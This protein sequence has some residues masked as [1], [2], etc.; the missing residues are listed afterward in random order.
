[1]ISRLKDCMA[2]EQTGTNSKR[3]DQFPENFPAFI[4]KGERCYVVG[5]DGKRYVDF[6]SAL[7]ANILGYAH[8]AVSEAVSKQAAKGS[9]FSLPSFKEVEVAEKIKGLIPSIEQLRFLKNGDDAARAAIRIARAYTNK[10][11]VLVKG[12]HGHSDLF[13]SLTPPSLGIK[14][15]FFAYKLSEDFLEIEKFGNSVACVLVE[16]LELSKSSPWREWLNALQKKC[17]KRGIVFIVDE[18]ITGFRVPTMS[19]SRWW[20]LDPDIVLL[21][22]AIANGYPLS[23]VGGKKKIM[24]STEY[25][26]SSTFSGDAVSLAAAEATMHEIETKKSLEDLMFYGT[27]LMN[28]LNDLHP[29]MKWLGWGTRA[30]FNLTH[31]ISALFAQEMCDAGYLFGKAWFFNFAHLEENIEALVMPVAE[32]VMTKIRQGN[33]KL[34]GKIPRETFEVRKS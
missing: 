10:Q 6:I 31:P 26:I 23:V 25:F 4:E 7:G 8:P 21:G 15:D 9:L 34:R 12:Y 33:V 27:R 29:D 19:L 14:D 22:K 5:N 16:A 17:R 1:M 18:I 24:N 20:D 28:R 13:T 30:S 11:V 3:R 32:A 2:Q